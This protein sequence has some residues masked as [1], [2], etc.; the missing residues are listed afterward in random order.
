MR[1]R[2]IRMKTG[3]LKERDFH[4][5]DFSKTM[6]EPWNHFIISVPKPDLQYD[7]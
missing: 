7:L 2:I 1:T 4:I 5:K 3:H 6:P